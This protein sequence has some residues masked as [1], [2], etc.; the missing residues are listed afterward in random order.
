MNIHI[1]SS[2]HI[3]RGMAKQLM[4]TVLAIV[5]LMSPAQLFTKG[6]FYNIFEG[7]VL[8]TFLISPV[9]IFGKHSLM[10]K[11]IF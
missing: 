2:F 4:K 9:L 8:M 6:Y 10:K 7:A 11:G 3:L 1:V 5:G